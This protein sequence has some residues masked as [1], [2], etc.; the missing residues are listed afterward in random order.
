MVL[1]LPLEYN[2]GELRLKPDTYIAT[3]ATF[4]AHVQLY[5]ELQL[6][7]ALTASKVLKSSG[8]LKPN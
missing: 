3:A 6:Y 8:S 4:L 2:A 7:A 1:A 5:W